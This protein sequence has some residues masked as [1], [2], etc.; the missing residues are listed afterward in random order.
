RYPRKGGAEAR[1]C[2]RSGASGA[3]SEG[4]CG[5][6]RGDWLANTD[7]EE[8]DARPGTARGSPRDAARPQ[9]QEASVEAARLVDHATL[10]PTER[11]G[12]A[13]EDAARLIVTSYKGVAPDKRRRSC[14]ARLP[15]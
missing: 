6:G 13:E 12:A 4:R 8:Q 1:L 7:P 2:S 11:E 9:R 3:G 14:P 5:S 15:A 10:R